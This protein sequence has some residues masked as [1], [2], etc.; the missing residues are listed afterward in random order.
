MKSRIASVILSQPFQLSWMGSAL[1]AFVRATHGAM[2]YSPHFRLDTQALD[3][4]HYAY[5]MLRA[6]ELARRLGHDR[7]SAIEFGVAGGNG[8]AFMCA[9]APE[10]KA[11]TGV[12]VDCY[13]FDTGEGMP[14]PEGAADLPYWFQAAQYRMDQDALRAKLPEARLVIG[15]VR[16]TL[17]GFLDSHAPAPIGAVFNDTDYW[18]ST[19]DSL[20]LFLQA[21]ERPEH[22]LPRIFNY[23]DDILGSEIEMYGPHN[24]QLRAIAEFNAAQED[25]KVHLNQNLIHQLHLR[26]RH[27]IYY[28]HVFC[29][30]DY[31]R[32]VGAENQQVIEDALK[33]R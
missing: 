18:S 11:A 3:R 17:A 9:F 4:P 6:A 24:G 19:R 10:V 1:R 27:Q 29:H 13:G 12:T 23:F 33:L 8:L 26:Y 30:P 16:D 28:A 5:C 15:N 7:I 22:F 20:S 14:P 32:Y 25:V 31:G 2:N 21:R